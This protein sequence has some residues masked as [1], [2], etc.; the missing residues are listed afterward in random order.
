MLN[1]IV[2]IGRLTADPQL[3]T[4]QAGKSVA[5]FRLAVDRP[6]YGEGEKQTDFIDVVCW[7]KLAEIVCNNLQKGRLVAVDG[8]LQIR[9]Y[10]W[11]GQKRTAAEVVAEDIRFLDGK[12]EQ[13][14]QQPQPQQQGYGT[15]AQYGSGGY[16]QQGYGYQQPGYADADKPD[17]PF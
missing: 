15:T 16:G 6:K 5:N 4:T 11:E 7:Q 17:V 1:R 2:L 10:D 3:R 9:Q 13:A 12:K 14:P 8:R